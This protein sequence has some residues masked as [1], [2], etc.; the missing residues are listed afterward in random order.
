MI[1]EGL[2]VLEAALA[3]RSPGPYQLQ[4]AIAALHAQAPS[5]ELTD[6]SEIATL[7]AELARQAPSPVVEVN[8]AVAVGMADGPHA[9]LAILG[10]VLAEGALREYAPLHAAH[11]D[12]LERAGEPDTA[13]Q[14]W[15][16]AI[17]A[18][19]NPA[20]RAELKRRRRAVES[21]GSQP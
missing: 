7:Y 16:R 14:A 20:L 12:L 1:A 15:Q 21:G 3:L 6:W 19:T 10:P 8:R 11:A 5:F 2:A 4:A 18:T 13:E 17:A 9:G